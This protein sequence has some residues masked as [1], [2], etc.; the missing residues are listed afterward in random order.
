MKLLTVTLYIFAGSTT[1]PP[2]LTS[3][4]P[5]PASA[6]VN[7]F[8]GI[9]FPF[10]SFRSCTICA[11]LIS[12]TTSVFRKGQIAFAAPYVI[13]PASR[14][15][16][17]PPGFIKAATAPSFSVAIKYES[18]IRYPTFVRS[19]SA[20]AEV[21]TCVLPIAS[22]GFRKASTNAAMSGSSGIDSSTTI[23]SGFRTLTSRPAASNCSFILPITL[24]HSQ[25]WKI[26][27][28]TPFKSFSI[29]GNGPIAGR[30]PSIA[31]VPSGV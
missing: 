23:G 26:G 18:A 13:L 24:P 30:Q 16:R 19:V 31:G 28:V 15:A 2:I 3:R 12:A 1:A 7:P 4:T 25:A 11:P 14:F 6:N 29:V 21:P 5:P 22:I 9:K 10:E 8:E 27:T 17:T 20:T